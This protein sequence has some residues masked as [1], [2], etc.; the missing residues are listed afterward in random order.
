MNAELSIT[1]STDAHLRLG[2][3]DNS[4]IRFFCGHSSRIDQ[5]TEGSNDG[6]LVEL[7]FAYAHRP[8]LPVKVFWPA[9]LQSDLQRFT[10]ARS[11][12]GSPK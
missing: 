2:L 8:R 5:I 6:I 12:F 11:T 9:A 10:A 7:S 3:F 4:Q 1:R